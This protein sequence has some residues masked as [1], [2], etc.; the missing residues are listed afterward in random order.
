[1]TP[2]AHTPGV[3]FARC[4]IRQGP[5]QAT[6][7]KKMQ[8]E[9]MTNIWGKFWLCAKIFYYGTSAETTCSRHPAEV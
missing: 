4:L 3:T 5:I 2:K 7:P 6:W 8:G 9:V 1:M